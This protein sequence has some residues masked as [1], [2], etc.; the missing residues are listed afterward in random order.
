MYFQDNY[1]A[2]DVCQF[3]E[4]IPAPAYRRPR[5]FHFNPILPINLTSSPRRSYRRQPAPLQTGGSSLFILKVT[6]RGSPLK[7]KGT[8]TDGCRGRSAGV[9]VEWDDSGG[10]SFIPQHKRS[11]AL[12]LDGSRSARVDPPRLQGVP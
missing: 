8:F 12:E 9:C 10:F 5:G 6:S 3:A 2:L 7:R 4:G 11:R 1:H